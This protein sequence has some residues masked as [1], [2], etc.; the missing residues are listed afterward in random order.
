MLYFN[1][2][3]L[4]VVRAGAAVTPA[5]C[6]TSVRLKRDTHTLLQGSP[7]LLSLPVISTWCGGLSQRD[8][9]LPSHL[10]LDRRLLAVSYLPVVRETVV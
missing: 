8:E 10:R 1:T 9:R 2:V 4:Q 5:F 7:A 6:R 3:F